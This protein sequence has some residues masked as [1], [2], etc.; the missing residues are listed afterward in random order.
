MM[1]DLIVNLE[2]IIHYTYYTVIIT[3]DTLDQLWLMMHPAYFW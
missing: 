3:A 1:T 2:K